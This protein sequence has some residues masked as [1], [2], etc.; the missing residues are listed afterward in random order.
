MQTFQM[1]SDLVV[2]SADGNIVALIEIKNV[3]DLTAET[4]ASIRRNLLMHGRLDFWSPFLMVL[5]QDKG[6]LWH[7]RSTTHQPTQPPTFEFSMQPV[8]ERYLP[9]F[10]GSERLRGSQLEL[11]VKQWLSDLASSD[12]DKTREPERALAKSGFLDSIRGG[13][14]G[15]EIT[16]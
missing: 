9:S 1:R 6:Y 12:A 11:A 15:T 7:Q 10:A 8:V 14:V 2:Q 5:S 4:A 13:L 16:L 3:P